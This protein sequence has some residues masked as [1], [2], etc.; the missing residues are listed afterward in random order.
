MERIYHLTNDTNVLD[1]T[2][3][4]PKQCGYAVIR[5]EQD[6]DGK[7]EFVAYL[8]NMEGIEVGHGQLYASEATALRYT[9]R[10][11]GAN[12]A[13]FVAQTDDY[14]GAKVVA[15]ALLDA[16]EGKFIV[17]VSSRDENFVD[18]PTTVTTALFATYD[19]AWDFYEAVDLRKH[20]KY[21]SKKSLWRR[22]YEAEFGKRQTMISCS[23]YRHWAVEC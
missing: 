4:M 2:R 14:N 6:A 21:E 8:F 10:R 19:E 1:N 7:P 22:T 23:E 18:S 11:A 16:D 17:N 5:D 3:D 15:G 9:K 12:A 13:E 20:G